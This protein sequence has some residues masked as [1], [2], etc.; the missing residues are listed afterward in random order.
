MKR[1]LP[2]VLLLLYIVEFSV[3]AVHPITASVFWVFAIAAV[4]L[5]FVRRR[6]VV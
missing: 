2:V 6:R 3:L 5:Y 1:N 4:V